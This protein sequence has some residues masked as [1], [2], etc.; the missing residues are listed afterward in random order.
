MHSMHRVDTLSPSNNM[1]GIMKMYKTILSS[2]EIKNFVDSLTS[3]EKLGMV[4][5]VS[6][7]FLVKYSIDNKMELSFHFN[8]GDIIIDFSTKA[9]IAS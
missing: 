5:L 8:R 4:S 2:N 6:I 1:K 3:S 7:V 9:L